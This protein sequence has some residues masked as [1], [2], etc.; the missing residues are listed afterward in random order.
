MQTLLN[1][2]IFL[3]CLSLV[4]C[5]HEAG[6]L[7]VAKL[8]GVYCSEYSIGFGPSFYT[9]KFKHK[10]KVIKDGKPV[11]EATPDGKKKP[12]YEVVE[13]ET[14]LSLRWLP[15][16]GYVAMAGEDGNLDD[17]GQVIPKERCLN[18]V[19]HFKQIC[20]MLAGIFLNF[21]LAWVLFFGA[22]LFPVTV[23]K[24]ESPAVY[25]QEG[26]LAAQAGLKNN[27]EIYY[28]YQEYQGLEDKNGNVLDPIIFPADD[29]SSVKVGSYLAFKS[30][31]EIDPNLPDYNNLK[32]DSLSYRVQDVIYNSKNNYFVAPEVFQDAHATVNSKRLI[33]FKS[34]SNPDVWKTVEVPSKQYPEENNLYYYA[35]DTLGITATTYVRQNTFGQAFVGSFQTFGSLFT[36]IYQAIGSLFTPSGWQSVGGIISV[37]KMSAQ[38]VSSGSFS[39]F[40]LLWGYISL[41]LG[42][43]NL[44]P[45]PGLDG[46]QTLIA[47][48]ETVTRK[49]MPTNIKAKANMIGLIVLMGLAALLVIKDFIMF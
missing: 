38:G 11:F 15:L 30:E 43:F 41:N 34:T 49:K 45:F 19:N 1:I 32:E 2:I 12:V 27:D 26:S 37:Y 47:L 31:G 3:L 5:V 21:V 23:Q 44:L 39:Y 20:I 7:L 42:C 10:K 28:I 13:G 16:G 6:H 17:K 33:H 35:F 48:G 8:C 14:Q 40:L 46:W 29:Y 9:H 24:T 22:S 25:V 4:V 18:G 36:G